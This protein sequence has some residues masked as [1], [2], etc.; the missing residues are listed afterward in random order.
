MFPTNDNEKKS[1][2]RTH[3]TFFTFHWHCWVSDGPSVTRWSQLI[4]LRRPKSR[5]HQLHN[6]RS[7]PGW[8]WVGMGAFK[9]F[10][11]VVIFWVLVP[12]LE[13]RADH[14]MLQGPRFV[15]SFSCS[16]TKLLYW[17][18]A[19]I[20]DHYVPR[21][22]SCCNWDVCVSALRSG[23]PK[24][25]GHGLLPRLTTQPTRARTSGIASTC[26]YRRPTTHGWHGRWHPR[27]VNDPT[28]E[29]SD[30][31]GSLGKPGEGQDK[32]YTILCHN[33]YQYYES[34]PKAWA[35]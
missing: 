10:K 25:T 33:T 9:M 20:A 3:G 19:G 5:I 24:K 4:G 14:I 23:T 1:P 35:E 22:E 15:I 18:I 12:G 13:H 26:H 8:S 27:K 30:F 34:Q 2:P 7:P 6:L 11:K 28:P 17:T 31:E 29:L 32:W 21:V 16:P